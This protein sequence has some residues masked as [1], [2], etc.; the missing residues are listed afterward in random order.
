M[1][2]FSAPRKVLVELGTSVDCYV[3]PRADRLIEDSILPH[4]PQTVVISIHTNLMSI[5]SHDP[6]AH[7]RGE[8]IRELLKP[9][10]GFN[11][12]TPG[13]WVDR[14]TEAPTWYEA[15]DTVIFRYANMGQ[16]PVEI[17]VISKNYNPVT[18]QFSINVAVNTVQNLSGSYYLCLAVTESNLIYK[19]EGAGSNYIHNFVLR[20]M[21]SGARGEQVSS[22]IWQQNQP[23][24]KSY[25]TFLDTG[26]IPS[27]CRYALYIYKSS[28]PD[29]MLYNCEIFQAESG[30]ITGSI[31][32]NPIQSEIKE[33]SL[34]QNYPNPFNPVTN[35]KFTISRK[36]NV[37]L[38]VYDLLGRERDNI[39]SGVLNAGTYNAEF[40]GNN[41]SSGIYFY[42]LKTGSY[43]EKKK[44]VLIK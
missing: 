22:G 28:Y 5:N 33:Y 39:F 19:Q 21:V 9:A 8:N 24:T 26:W 10:G 2:V 17:N 44:M 30:S 13:I 4:F 43:C 38:K 36:E 31:G 40:S 6:Y 27:N 14:S 12:P 25:T 3:C 41:L 16:T 42:V 23:V 11:F 18:R 37:S 1:Q 7:F 15:Y 29:T 35:I 20:D 32:V 34:S